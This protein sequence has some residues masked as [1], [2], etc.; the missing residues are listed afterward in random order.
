M[1]TTD[2]IA[3]MLTRI[4]NA[5]SAK[6]KTV[7]VPSS[8]MKTAIAEILFKEGYIK[9]FELISNENQGIIRIT[10]KYDEKGNVI[11]KTEYTKGFLGIFSVRERQ[12]DIE[13]TYN[14][15]GDISQEFIQIEDFCTSITDGHQIYDEG[16]NY[17]ETYP[18]PRKGWWEG[19]EQ[20]FQYRTLASFCDVRGAFARWLNIKLTQLQKLFR[21]Q[22]RLPKMSLY[23]GIVY[24][25]LHKDFV[26]WMLHDK[27]T[28]CILNSLKNTTLA[29]EVFF[30]TIIMNSPYKE[31]CAKTNLRY[32]DWVTNAPELKILDKED[33]STII[34]T[35]ALFCRKV[36]EEKSSQL[37]KSLSSL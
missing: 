1:N 18:L 34:R 6:H 37:L 31:K 3:D 32:M 14:E 2:P 11:K 24:S 7:D 12:Y 23:S 13:Y 36:D 15:N 5:N 33:L 9:S 25:S 8:K 16:Y 30:Q 21:L 27:K 10:L 19:G 29:E 4:R 17:I 28:L 20:I 35:K 22:R 26:N